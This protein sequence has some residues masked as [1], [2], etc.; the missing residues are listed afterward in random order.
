MDD[1]VWLDAAVRSRAARRA[2]ELATRAL[3]RPLSPFSELPARLVLVDVEG[4]RL[5]LL[6][7]D[8][9]VADY[10]VSTAA[11]G[12]G[13]THGSLRTPPG[14]HRIHERIGAGQPL[15]AVFQSREPTGTVWHG[16]PWEE[17]LILTR[18]LTLEGL[19]PGVNQ[20]EGVDSLARY[21]YIHGTNHERSLG[22][23]AS[24][25]CV[26]V[27]NAHMAELFE[28]VAAGDPVAIVSDERVDVVPDPHGP[29]RFHY[30]GLAGSGMSALAQFQVM[31]GGRASGSDRAFDR[32]ERAEARTQLERLGITVRPQDGSGVEGDCAALVAST[33]VEAEV[34]D[35]AGARARGV[36]IVH[37]SD[38]LARF[39]DEHRTIAIAGTSGKSTT[40]AMAFE[41]LRGAGREP[42]VITGGDLVALQQQGLWGNAWAG[43]SE[44]LVVEA[45]ESDGSLVKY[46]P[47]V[48]VVLNLQR[49]HREMHEV[50]EMFAIFRSRTQERLVV[51]EADN[52]RSLADGALVFG[53]GPE[54]EIRATEVELDPDGCRFRVDGVDFR[55][56]VP[57]IHNVENALGAIAACRAIDVPLA[58]MVEPLARIQGVSRRFQ[59]I[60]KARDVEVVDD[61]AHNP[62]KLRAAIT[63][64][65]RRAR[66]VLAVYQ[67]HGYGPTRFLRADF[68]ETFAEA[69]RP[70]DR[71]WLLEIFYA[72]GTAQRDFSAAD[73][74]AEIA[75]RGT[76]AEFAPDRSGL[77]ERIA[78][79]ARPGDLVLVMGARDPSLTGL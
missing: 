56:P 10:P 66:R 23:P 49:D 3:A 28:Q 65:Q 15:G 61:F 35:V 57:G 41:I 52:L 59:V 44:L 26:R 71:L 50:A 16:E 29:G 24:H 69:L 38:L 55:L 46:R 36:P 72:G 40:V 33:A 2:L 67:P 9:V 47:A 78:G 22:H 43:T 19:E 75:A 34:P 8:Q 11:A 53:F 6:R 17:D 70:E 13:G 54:A 64:A 63:T 27:S 42:S 73:I 51:G 74:I 20:G 1:S 68:V 58:A 7:G 21:I 48:G 18:V 39:V 30:A 12:I 62:A 77:V 4:Q 32:G 5:F 76:R 25:G 45:D 79:E 31:T 60:G 37:R 14:W